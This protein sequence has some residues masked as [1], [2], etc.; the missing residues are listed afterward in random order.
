MPCLHSR[1][2]L[3]CLAAV[4]AAFLFG[5]SARILAQSDE[6]DLL[7]TDVVQLLHT[8]MFDI[9]MPLA[10]LA[11]ERTKARHGEDHPRY[12]VALSNMA[13]LLQHTNRLPEAEP[14]MRRV[15]AIFEKALGAEHSNVATALNNL[16]LLLKHT[17]RLAEG[18]AALSPLARHPTGEL[19]PSLSCAAR[20]PSTR[21][22]SGPSIPA[23][24]EL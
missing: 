23:S 21:R 5:A 1:A 24:P 14:L 6:I 8:G 16:A 13:A 12:A 17:N 2:V 10:E 18:R 22:A 20:L 3:G 9:A 4:L 7:N 11:V 15:L 19:R